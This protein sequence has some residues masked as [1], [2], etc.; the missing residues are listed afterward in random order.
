MKK[1]INRLIINET[2]NKPI[3][4]YIETNIVMHCNLN[5]RGCN[6]FAPLYSENEDMIDFDRWTK[7]VDRIAE[8]FEIKKFGILGGE[9]L[10]HPRWL[11]FLRY[12]RNK[13]PNALLTFRTNG[14]LSNLLVANKKELEDLK[15]ELVISDYNLSLNID[16][17]L[18]NRTFDRIK[19]KFE[20]PSI[21]S[22]G[23]QS[24]TDSWLQCRNKHCLALTE[25]YIYC[26]NYGLSF[27]KLNEYFDLKIDI[28]DDVKINIFNSS[29]NDIIKWTRHAK[30]CCKYCNLNNRKYD[31]E[32][33]LSK[34]EKSEWII[35]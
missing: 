5:C 14:I 21:D 26:C 2:E 27:N 10:L 17:S 29:A 18:F 3:L 12:L 15:V 11:D 25:D 8:M 34:K 30:D 7:A 6:H 31:Q 33:G 9:P 28:N 22:E 19:T 1:D 4:N 16:K 23:N 24:K 20:H 32:W 13:L 35:N